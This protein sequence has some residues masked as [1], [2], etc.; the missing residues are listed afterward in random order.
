MSQDVKLKLARWMTLE[1]L[2][3]FGAATLAA[4]EQKTEGNLPGLFDLTDAQLT[5]IGL[6][7]DQ[8]GILRHPN[9]DWLDRNFAWEARSSKYFLLG[10]DSADYPQQLR[11]LSRPPLL[12]YGQGNR[13]C[14]NAPQVAIV[15]SRNPTLQGRQLAFELASQLSQAGFVITSGMALG[16]DGWAHK[17]VVQQ[18]GKT[19][20]VL[21]SGLEQIYPKRHLQL[22]DQIVQSQGCLLSEF[23]PWQR[24]CADHFPRRNRIISGLSLGTVVIEAAIRSGSLITARYA[25]EQDRDVFAVPGSVY[26]PLSKGCHYLIKQGAR[27]VESAEDII[28][29]YQNVVSLGGKVSD[30]DAEKNSDNV[31]ARDRLLDSVDYEITPVDVITQRSGLPLKAVLS[32]LLEY[33]L[34]G[35]VITAPGGYIKLRGK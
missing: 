17:G 14:L 16:I 25:L 28:E 31:L 29:E 33:E 7:K 8:I 27:L 23:A 19:I 12:L 2:P 21:G 18:G 32:E 4:L 35:L 34:R 26:N 13:H 22:A 30:N 15:G 24:A 11:E 6:S 9:Q 20:A 3:R 10:Y 5:S 1:Q